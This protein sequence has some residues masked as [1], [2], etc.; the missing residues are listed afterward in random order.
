MGLF[1]WILYLICGIIFYFV[2][3]FINSKI[4]LTKIDKIVFLNIFNIIFSGLL[5]RYSIQYTD[6]IFLVFVFVLLTDIIYNTYIVD[7]DFFDK[8]KGGIS[9][10]IV[11]VITGFIINQEFINKVN[12][13]FLSGKEFRIVLWLLFIVYLYNFLKNEKIFKKN[14]SNDNKVISVNNILSNYAKFKY[15]YSD[16][17][18]FDNKDIVN[19]LFA[20]MIYEDNRRNKVMR[21]FDCL[22]FKL[23][24]KKNKF[25]IMQ[26]ESKKFISDS[27]SID[28]AY[29]KILRIY[30]SIKT[31]NKDYNKVFDKYYGYDNSD[32][33]YIFEIIRKI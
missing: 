8:E 33:K 10:Y 17:C 18:N 30:N 6:N 15:A 9:Y 31:K 4:S 11:L 2:I 20:I 1:G 7:R 12:S 23:N 13:I 28:L 3:E 22:L 26:I 29:K 27:E 24:G 21:N 14:I 16:D 25:G 19:I 32:V 5:F